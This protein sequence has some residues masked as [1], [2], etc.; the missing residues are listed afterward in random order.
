MFVVTRRLRKFAGRR[1]PSDSD[2]PLA[3]AQ[4]RQV[5]KK[6]ITVLKRVHFLLFDLCAL[7]RDNPA[8]G[9]GCSPTGE[10]LFPS[11]VWE[12][13]CVLLRKYA[14]RDDLQNEEA[15]W[16][17]SYPRKRVSRLMR[18]RTNLDSRVRGNDESRKALY[19][20]KFLHFHFL[21]ASVSS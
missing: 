2:M 4:R 9:C 11:A 1:T 10:P 20:G 19:G 13:A 21:W 15:A 8:F 12:K 5:R 16:D 17:P 18:R 6:Q 7:A 14:C 3:K